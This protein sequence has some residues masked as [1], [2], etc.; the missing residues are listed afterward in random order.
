M[1]AS[2]CSYAPTSLPTPT[3]RRDGIVSIKPRPYGV[4][5]FDKGL[6]EPFALV[7]NDASASLIDPTP[8]SL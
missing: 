4:A 6:A 5:V 1:K 7:L 8:V 2:T 3:A